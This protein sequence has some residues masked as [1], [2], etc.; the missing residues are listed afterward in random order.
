MSLTLGSK[1][2]PDRHIP[3]DNQG[4]SWIAQKG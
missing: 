3:P 4:V 1:Y 2:T